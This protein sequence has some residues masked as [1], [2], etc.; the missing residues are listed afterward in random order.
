M[1]FY[2]DLHIHSDLSPCSA[3]DMT[4]NNIINMSLIKGLDIISVTDHNSTGRSSRRCS[5]NNSSVSQ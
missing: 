4:P 3:C 5:S 2:Y 1:K